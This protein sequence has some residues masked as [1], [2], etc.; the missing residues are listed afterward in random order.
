MHHENAK[1]NCYYIWPRQPRW[2]RR[3]WWWRIMPWLQLRFEYDTTTIR[4]RHD[5]D[6]SH[7]PAS[8]R[9]D[10]TRAKN[11]HVDFRRSRIVVESQ[12][13]NCDIPFRNTHGPVYDAV[14]VCR[15]CAPAA[16]TWA[17]SQSKAVAAATGNQH[18]ADQSQGRYLYNAARSRSIIKLSKR[19]LIDKNNSASASEVTNVQRYRN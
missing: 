19:T 9:R 16:D 8:I 3:W 4:L 6:V 2:R 15:R 7:A 14:R 17:R 12:I 18:L 13:R 10:S 1:G 5:Y 11:E